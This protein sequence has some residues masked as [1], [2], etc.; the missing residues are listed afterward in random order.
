[1]PATCIKLTKV[2]TL[3][4]IKH[5]PKNQKINME[6][7]TRIRYE[8]IG[9]LIDYF[10]KAKFR[11]SDSNPALLGY[12]TIRAIRAGI[13]MGELETIFATYAHRQTQPSRTPEAINLEDQLV[14]YP[15]TSRTPSKP[16]PVLLEEQRDYQRKNPFKKDGD[17]PSPFRK[18]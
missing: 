7:N 9:E 5:K 18:D 4:T 1:M 17:G 16:L 10:E 12:L 14:D 2:H 3:I 15:K 11:D 8:T 6:K 13:K